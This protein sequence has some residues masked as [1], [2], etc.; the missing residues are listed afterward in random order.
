MISTT[1]S[2]QWIGVDI[3]SISWYIER[4][5]NILITLLKHVVN[6]VTVYF[7]T[8]LFITSKSNNYK[9]DDNFI[10]TY[11]FFSLFHYFTS[12]FFGDVIV[13]KTLH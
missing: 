5:N 11:D 1:E 10:E 8:Q 3:S 13:R 6:R 2:V 4:P 12:K 7:G 9:H